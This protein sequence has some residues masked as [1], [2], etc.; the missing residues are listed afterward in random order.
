MK[1]KGKAQLDLNNIS[2]SNLDYE[3][4]L[5]HSNLGIVTKN[6]DNNYENGICLESELGPIIIKFDILTNKNK[7][8][9][10]LKDLNMYLSANYKLE[11]NLTIG[12]KYETDVEQNN[13]E[14][15]S[16]TI[17]SKIKN[18]NISLNLN[19]ENIIYGYKNFDNK[20]INLFGNKINPSLGLL[21][22]NV[23]LGYIIN[24]SEEIDE[25]GNK[26]NKYNNKLSLD[27]DIKIL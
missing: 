15:L 20:K 10:N 6:K 25:Y 2:I 26:E 1:L 4:N 13:F 14:I 19:S 27:L 12:L 11:E 24:Q 23:Y 8:P 18:S 22:D 7:F 9:D 21:N 5:T 3:L 17:N 16:G